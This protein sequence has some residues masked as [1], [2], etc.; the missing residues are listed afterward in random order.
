MIV[1]QWFNNWDIKSNY[2][3]R[4][5]LKRLFI[6]DKYNYWD[7]LDS[8]YEI[9]KNKILELKLD[10]YINW[11]CYSVLKISP[12]RNW[13]DLLKSNNSY[14]MSRINHE[15]TDFNFTLK[16]SQE[17]NRIDLE[18]RSKIIGIKKVNNNKFKITL[19]HHSDYT[20]KSR[21]VNYITIERI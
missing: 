20:D 21:Y 19:Y 11:N 1:N 12:K 3:F 6:I 5:E 14:L 7:L 15:F 13:S 9:Y 16:D 10:K 8:G 18:V 2:S 4:I 17:N